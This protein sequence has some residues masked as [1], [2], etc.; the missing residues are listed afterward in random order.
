MGVACTYSSKH[1]YFY[2][3]SIGKN[4][5]SLHSVPVGLEVWWYPELG[6]TLWNGMKLLAPIGIERLNFGSPARRVDTTLTT[7]LALS[8]LVQSTIYT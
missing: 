6:W 7:I 4:A 8:N 3:I 2:N 1:D 5:P